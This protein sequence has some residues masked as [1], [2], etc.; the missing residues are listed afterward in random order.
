MVGR[1]GCRLPAWKPAENPDPV[2]SLAL[3]SRSAFKFTRRTES[4]EESFVVLFWKNG[5]FPPAAREIAIGCLALI[6]TE[7]LFNFRH[8][9]YIEP[10][11]PALCLLLALVTERLLR[12]RS[13]VRGVTIAALSALLLAG[14]VQTKLQI[15]F[16]R[17]KDFTDEK[18]VAEKLGALQQP[19]FRTVL[20]KAINP[21]S[22]LHFASFYLFHGNLRLPIEKYSVDELRQ[23][24]PPPP[25][26]GV[27][28][29]R[30][31]PVVETA[32]AGVHTEFARGEF[33]VWK[34][35]KQSA[36]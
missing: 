17:R 1:D 25:L 29:A 6:A 4:T 27:C 7:I 32:Y 34:V 9:R 21:G 13:V 26:V 16:R 22:D 12:G 36:P 18:L 20:V 10:I 33:V 23:S 28:V 3:Y 31:F 19:G 30:D 11:I 5:Q 15:D 2:S 14:F 8:V 24:P 35:D